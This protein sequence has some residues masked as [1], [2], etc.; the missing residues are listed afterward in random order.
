MSVSPGVCKQQSGEYERD[1]WE[2]ESGLAFR[3]VTFQAN[4]YMQ[5]CVLLLNDIFHKFMMKNDDDDD[6]LGG[7]WE[8]EFITESNKE[9]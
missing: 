8:S 7:F 5:V 6:A 3:K 4:A 1:G 9:V 2:K